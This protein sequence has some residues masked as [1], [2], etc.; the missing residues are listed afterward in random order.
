MYMAGLTGAVAFVGAGSA[1]GSATPYLC[2]AL[3]KF[4]RLP[5]PQ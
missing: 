4:I 2:F 5:S 3:G 1:N